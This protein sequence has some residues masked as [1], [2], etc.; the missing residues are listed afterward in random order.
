[1]FAVTGGFG[2]ESNSSGGNKENINLWGNITQ[3]ERKAVGMVGG[4]GYRKRYAHD[5]RMFYD[6]PPHILEPTNVGWEIQEWKE[7]PTP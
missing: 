3:K 2:Y 7:I 1:M 5:P 4:T 6:Y